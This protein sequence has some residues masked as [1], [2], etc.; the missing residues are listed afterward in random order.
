MFPSNSTVRPVLYRLMPTTVPTF[1][2]RRGQRTAPSSLIRN[3]VPIA[4]LSI[5]LSIV[6]TIDCSAAKNSPERDP[7]CELGDVR[8]RCGFSLGRSAMSHGPACFYGGGLIGFGPNSV[9]V[10][11]SRRPKYRVSGYTC[12]RLHNCIRRRGSMRRR[13]ATNHGLQVRSR[14]MSRF[15]RVLR[16]PEIVAQ[17]SPAPSVR[18]QFARPAQGMLRKVSAASCPAGAD[19]RRA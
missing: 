2:A 8:A 1:P 5:W 10:P 16:R 3:R 12:K 19:N 9:K 4:I 15:T 13:A 11:H 7:S 17:I 6:L 14:S 18:R